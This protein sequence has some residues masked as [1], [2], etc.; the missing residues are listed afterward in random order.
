MQD[1]LFLPAHV[2]DEAKVHEKQDGDEIIEYHRMDI[3]W[4]YLENVK[5][6]V[7]GQPRFSMLT[8]VAKLVLTLPHSNKESFL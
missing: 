4:S 2:W 8:K 6:T 1:T 3:L 7:T 5:D